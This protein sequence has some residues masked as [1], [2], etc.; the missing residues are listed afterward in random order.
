MSWIHIGEAPIPA[1]FEIFNLP[2]RFYALFILGGAI[3]AYLLARRYLKKA[4]FEAVNYRNCLDVYL[5]FSAYRQINS[6]PK[7]KRG[8]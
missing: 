6:L 4:G 1:G 3:L 7:R 5:A 8:N 2:I